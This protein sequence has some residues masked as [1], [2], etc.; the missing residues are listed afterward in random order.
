MDTADSTS[1][2]PL[3]RDKRRQD[4]QEMLREVGLEVEYWLPKLQE[5]LG[6]TCAEALQHIEEK[7]LQKLKSQAQHS[8]EKRALEKLL[9]SNSLS[10]LQESQVKMMKKEQKKAK[11]ALQELRDLL[12]QGRQRKEETV[13]KKEAELRQAM[14]IPKEYWPPPEKSLREVI[15]NMQGQLNLM[16]GTLSHRQNLPDRDLV[17]WASGGLALQGIYKTSYQI[18]LVQKREELLS[19]PKEFSIFGPEHGTRME[20]R[21]FTSSQEE[22]QFTQ[23]T[24]KLGFSLIASAKGGGWGFSFEAGM[25]HSKHSESKETQ[26]SRSEHSYFC[27]TK[28]SY[29]PLASCAFPMDQ[30]QFSKAALQELKCIDDLLSQSADTDRL[31][32]L[33][34]STE[35]FFHRF[36]SHANQGPLHLGGIYWWKAVSEGFRS[37]Q[38]AEVKQ[39]SAEALNGYIRGSYSGFGVKVAAGVDESHSHSE[40]S[41]Q[42]TTFQNLQTKVQLSVAQ[43]GGPPEANGFLQW[44]AGLVASNQTWSV[45]DRGLQLVPIWDII[46]SNHRSDFKDP[47]QV[48]SLLK[49]SYTALT[50]ITAQIQDGEELLSAEEEAGVSLEDVKSWEVSDPKEQL[51]KLINFMQI[52]SQKTNSYNTWVN[53]CLTNLGLQNF[54]VKTVNFCKQSSIYERKFI[55]SQLHSLLYPHIYRVNDFPKTR[56]IMQWVF[57]A[58]SVQEHINI[59]QFSQ[60]NTSLKKIKNDLMEAMVISK[61]E[62]TEAQRK[63]TYEVS[64]SLHCFL[65]Y[66]QETEQ[67]DTQL[68]L[69]SIAAGAGFH[70]VNKHF[71]HFLGCEELDFLMNEMQMAQHKYQ[72]L[73]KNCTYR[74]Q[75]FLVLTSLTAT[76]R[77]TAVSPEEKT[78]RLTLIK[79]HLGKSLSKEVVHVLSKQGADYDWE[80]LEKDLRLLIDGNYDATISSL[81]MDDISKNLQSI[82]HVRKQPH[83]PHENGD[84]K[85]EVIKDTA[86]LELLQHLGLEHFY[87]KKMSKTHFHLINKT[88]VYNSQPISE[89]ELHQCFLQKLQVLD[90][91]LRYLVF[92]DDGDTLNQV[93]PSAS[94]EGNEAFNPYK[95]LFEDSNAPNIP[96]PSKPRPHIHPMDIQMAILHCADDFARQY[97]LS[98]LSI[99]QFAL[100]LLIPNPCTSQI[101]FSLWSLS[102]IRRSWQEARKSPREEKINYKN[103]QMCQ[104]STPIVS[105][106]RVGNGFSASKSQIMN[107]LLSKRKHDAFFHRHCRGSTK[108]CLLMGGVVEICWFCPAGEDDDRFYNCVTFTNLH[109]DAKKHKKQLTFLQEV[110]SLIVVLMST[111]DDNKENQKIIRDLSQS[112]KPLIYLVDNKERNMD[113]NSSQKVVIGIRNR[114]EAELTEELVSTIR[115]LLEL[116]DTTLSLEDCTPIARKQGFLIDEDQRDCREAKEKAEV[117][118]ALLREFNISQVKENLLPLQGHLWHLWCKKD[119]ELYHLREKGNRSIEQHKSEIETEKQSIRSQQLKRAFPLNELMQSVLEIL[120]NH[121]E[122]QTTHYFL[123]WMSVFLDNLTAGHL[124][125]LSEKKNNLWSLIQTEKQKA[126][127]STDLQ[128]WQK[129]IEAISTEI[130]DCTLGIEQLLRE[131]GQIYE[132]LEE[133]SPTKNTLYLS[134]PQIAADLMI[135]GVPIELMDGDVSYVPLKWVAALFDKVSEKLGNKRLFVLSVLGLQSSGK[136]TLLNALFGLQFTVSAGRCTR[137][138][139]MQLLKVEDTFT[140]ELG[141]DFVLVVDTGGLRAPE[142]SNKSNNHDNELATFVIGLG[143]LTLIN[144]FGENPSEMQDIL[145]I[146]V[147]AFMRMKQVK[148][149]PSC[150]FVHQN[151]GEVTAKDQTMEGRRRLEQRLDEMA[152]TAAEQEQCSNVTCF[153]DIIKFD[154]N[155]N[156]FY[157]AHLWDGNPPMAPPNPRYSHNVQDLKRRILMAA[158][159]ESMGSIMK[160]SDVKLRVQDLWRAL[161]SE[162]FIFS[163]RNTQEVVSMS[164]LEDMYHSWTW[165]LRSYVL[166]LQNQLINQIKN[167]KI[168]ELKASTLQAPVTEKYEAIQQELE[169]YFKEDPDSEIIIQ[170]KAIFETKL[171]NLKDSLIFETKKRAEEHICYKKNQEILDNKMS[172][173]EKELLVKSVELALTLKDKVLSENELHVRFNDL[174]KNW[175]S[176][177]FS[178]FPSVPE[179]EIEVDGEGILLEHFKKETNMSNRVKEKSRKE[180]EVNYE[181]HVTMSK[182]FGLLKRN[183]EVHDE[184]S[185]KETTDHIIS[186]Y[187]ENFKNLQ[188]QQCDYDPS[189][190]HQILNIIE[191]EVK[192]EATKD[193]YAFTNKYKIDLSLYLFQRAYENFKEMHRAF[194]KTNDPVSYLESKKDDFLMGFKISCQGAT[195]IKTFVEFLLEKLTPAVHDTIS[196]KMAPKIAG[197][198]IATCPA[199]SGNRANLEKHVLIS[200]AEKENFDDYWEYIQNPKSFFKNYIQNHTKIYCSKQ[201]NKIKTF[202][203]KI[204]HSIKNAILSAIHESTAQA[205]NKSSAVSRWLDLFCDHLGN[206][207]NFPRKYLVS[208]QHQEIKDIELLNEAMSKA[209]DEL[210]I[211]IE[212]TRFSMP[213][214]D[215]ILE[216]QSMLSEHLCGCWK[217]CPFCGAICTNT[218]P[219]HDGDHSVPFHRPKAVAGGQWVNTNHFNIDCCTSLVASNYSFVLNG[220]DIPF[221][222]YRQAGGEFAKWSITPDTST[223]PY[224]KWFVCHFRSNLEEKY[225]KKFTDKGKIPNAWT[226]ITKQNVLDDLKKQ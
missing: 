96:S 161:L 192:S 137:G 184:E 209:L 221:K 197:D 89:S 19:V 118:I 122:T 158:K 75:A 169:K 41:I 143:N 104:V 204:I 42:S 180:F 187:T 46:L 111:T 108:D 217:Q 88:S 201:N 115:C 171:V 109:G 146:V 55:K 131:V 116:S 112:L 47:C 73:K 193:R 14:E 31:P 206:N 99:C 53:K 139:Y 190:F 130:S 61:S 70:V 141:F 176:G 44:K 56:S 13:R 62:E 213:E 71:Q 113:N 183:I 128:H 12:S 37:E 174:W 94:N 220:H 151:V 4:L 216:I 107:C 29:I 103:K 11:Q 2:D 38:L 170:W 84:I 105:F 7:D 74:A 76:I 127:K 224:W 198:M 95:Y 60:L 133:A 178:T 142:L 223:Q 222:T 136:S 39:Q 172:S 26:Q 33:R 34:R 66:L 72:E 110:S 159:Q 202:L 79:H 138:A 22:S 125:K 177:V 54:L 65:N 153:G 27:S 90:Y 20:T 135:S 121:S 219:N 1:N 205:K 173:Y 210:M 50:G 52:L 77:V 28:F 8:W 15:E 85:G 144:I 181:E 57:Q 179:P 18:E 30:L 63:A 166:D 45:I 102:Q 67:P 212:K 208:I 157:F 195:S 162:N 98:K 92:R 156:V 120:Q 147:Q 23:M 145:Q 97:I 160:I 119:K 194:K 87:P 101:E 80:N 134:L 168:Q 132:A 32:V 199:F 155:T 93:N 185:I 129:E 175:V 48:A 148:I 106:I 24:E 117:L 218:I 83:K 203:G 5:Q 123:Q 100:P 91:E 188:R 154:V 35:A 17:R 3:L 16:E 164:K 43:T 165:Q 40:T 140:E 49:D 149:S 58:K 225:E 167:G 6:V 69:L 191:E 182:R 78:Q 9:N 36:G 114:N 163:F 226:K 150:L 126:P 196:E 21:E 81:Q 186:R 82:F 189:Y 86:F 10:K 215:M 152:T 51:Q 68:L 25:D 200:L 64:L 207:L 124:E 214:E 59:S 211:V